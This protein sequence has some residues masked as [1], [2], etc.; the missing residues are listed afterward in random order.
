MAAP[1]VQRNVVIYSRQT[2]SLNHENRCLYKDSIKSRNISPSKISRYTVLDECT[3]ELKE[4]AQ[5]IISTFDRDSNSVLAMLEFYC[6]A[7]LCSRLTNK[8]S[9]G[10]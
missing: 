5:M 6:C 1:S 4:C 9:S 8:I 10:T 3:G 7:K 2:S